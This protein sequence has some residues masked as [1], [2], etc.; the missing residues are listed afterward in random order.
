[1]KTTIISLFLFAVASAQMDEMKGPKIIIE[2]R[3]QIVDA[4]IGMNTANFGCTAE[5]DGELVYEWRFNGDVITDSNSDISISGGQLRIT[6]A[7]RTRDAGMYQC[8]VSNEVGT[9]FSRP[10]ELTFTFV[11]LFPSLNDQP[12]VTVNEFLSTSLN[13]DAPDNYPGLEYSWMKNGQYISGDRRIRVGKDGYL[14]FANTFTGANGDTGDYV[15]EIRNSYNN[16]S[17]AS[18][19]YGGPKRPLQVSASR[20]Q[21]Y[22]PQVEQI[23]GTQNV[24]EGD[25]VTLQCFFSGRPTPSL[26][27]TRTDGESLPSGSFQTDYSQELV[28]PNIAIEDAGTYRCSASNSVQSGI[29]NEGTVIVRSK[30]QWV[31]EIEDK[32]GDIGG[33]VIWTCVAESTEPIV[34]SWY[35]NGVEVQSSAKYLVSNGQRTLTIS[36]LQEDDDAMFQCEAS[37]EFGM[38][39]STAQ[40]NVRAFAPIFYISV[41]VAQPAALGQ[42]ATL[43]CRPE[44]AP[45]ARIVWQREGAT[46]QWDDIRTNN[47]FFVDDNSGD[48]MIMDVHSGDGGRYRCVASND[49]GTNTSTGSI[50]VKEGVKFFMKPTD[51]TIRAGRDN[52]IK[53]EARVD[54]LLELAYTWLFNGNQLHLDGEED[55]D[56]LD[57][58]HYDMDVEM[59]DV[60][61]NLVIK[62]TTMYQQGEYTCVVTSP[63]NQ[64]SASAIITVQGPPGAPYGVRIQDGSATATSVALIWSSGREGG[65]PITSY[66]VEAMTNHI[67]EWMEIQRDIAPTADV[68]KDSVTLI[69]LSPWSVYMFRVLAVN[70]FGAGEPSDSS[71]EFT[72][73]PAVPTKAPSNLGG[74]GGREGQLRITWQPLGM[75]DWNAPSIYYKVYWARV[76]SEGLQQTADVNNGTVGVFEVEGVETF[77]EYTVQIQAVND[78]GPGPMS[79]PVNIFSYEEAPSTAPGRV[80]LSVQSAMTIRVSWNA[81]NTQ[82]VQ[83]QFKGYK[84]A[85]WTDDIPESSASIYTTSGSG[86]VSIIDKLEAY[87]QYQFRVYAYTAGGKGPGSTIATAR[88][89][90]SAPQTAPDNVRVTF[91]KQYNQLNINWDKITTSSNEEQLQGYRVCYWPLGTFEDDAYY[92]DVEVPTTEV[93]LDRL[94]PDH[95]YLIKVKGY[96]KGGIGVGQDEPIRVENNSQAARQSTNSATT[97]FYSSFLVACVLQLAYLLLL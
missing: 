1:M 20:D 21:N 36:D 84:I 16:P 64:V 96:S 88:T 68:N 62:D 25:T 65:S 14:Y 47:K 57:L 91:G 10:A 27:W 85:Y 67:Q 66:R 92:E 52:T 24:L 38:I 35:R 39:I 5:G 42:N 30:P 2:P 40:L 71:P 72:T 48:L 75:E 31:D 45:K 83:G 53:C 28:I 3:D 26:S 61:G 81:I 56:E 63:I 43:S 11:D 44:A 46:N 73:Q 59:I 70:R 4:D 82:A 41:N 90:R 15:C 23:I 22:A 51:Q 13:C 32:N 94:Y 19:K 34:Y 93:M 8:W 89:Y 7:E 76:G 49:L 37:N 12:T 18:N 78:P 97:M 9:V 29:S 54:D 60:H 79:T 55:H 69:N 58:K 33:E 77:I 87:T 80:R 74:G 17:G 6:N 95:V 86:T 50:E